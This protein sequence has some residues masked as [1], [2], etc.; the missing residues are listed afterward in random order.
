MLVETNRTNRKQKES[1]ITL[2]SANKINTASVNKIS[3]E[4]FSVINTSNL[5]KLSRVNTVHYSLTNFNPATVIRVPRSKIKS[6]SKKRSKNI[7]IIL[8]DLRN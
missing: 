2:I 8:V 5:R 3:A 4:D 6:I 1:L 7:R